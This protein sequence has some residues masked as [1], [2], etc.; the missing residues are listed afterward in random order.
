[1]FSLTNTVCIVGSCR[2]V[3]VGQ[4]AENSAKTDGGFSEALAQVTEQ[5]GTAT[6]HTSFGAVLAGVNPNWVPDGTVFYGNAADAVFHKIGIGEDGCLSRAEVVYALRNVMT[7][8]LA[9]KVYDAIDPQGTNAVTLD[10][11]RDRMNN[12]V[13][14]WEGEYT[15]TNSAITVSASTSM[16]SGDRELSYDGTLTTLRDAASGEGDEQTDDQASIRQ[17]QTGSGD[18]SLWSILL[19]MLYRPG[20]AP[21]E[22]GHSAAPS[23][24]TNSIPE[25]GSTAVMSATFADVSATG[26]QVQCAA[27]GLLTMCV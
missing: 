6:Q 4:P 19:N 9:N 26:E 2:K 1:M 25:S 7:P 16:Q 11:L 8:E 3:N 15:A 13:N 5:I 10:Q 12:E 23:A 14:L 27:G 17:A 21:I 20:L 18:Q 24:L 22:A